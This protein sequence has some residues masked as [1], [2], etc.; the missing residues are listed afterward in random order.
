MKNISTQ[1]VQ[2][3][4]QEVTTVCSCWRLELTDG[5]ILGFTDHVDDLV[6]EG[7][8][9][10]AMT[11]FNRTAI[12]QNRNFK[13]DNHDITGLID[14]LTITESDLLAGR[15]ANAKLYYF[16]VNYE[17]LTQGIVKLDVGYLGDI[18]LKDGIFIAS[19]NSITRKLDQTIG[20]KYSRYCR[21]I[22]GDA[23]CGVHIPKDIWRPN[24]VYNVGDIV[25][26]P[27]LATNV[28]FICITAGTSNISGN[29]LEPAWDTTIG[30]TILDTD[31][32][33]QVEASNGK[34]GQVVSLIDDYS[35]NSTV[36]DADSWYQK[37][38]LVFYSG[39]NTGYSF[40]VK[41]S[42]STGEIQLLTKIYNEINIGDKFF[43]TVGCNH[44]LK[45]ADGTYN[46]DCKIKFNNVL[47][48]GGEPEI[49]GNN[50]ILAGA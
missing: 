38:T 14:S 27:T 37:G 46:G 43:I 16:E 28:Q 5:T 39:A 21:H 25:L 40:D 23:N 32:V 24:T 34:I 1:L 2:H 36:T 13:V 9:Y 29:G 18:T 41:Q 22:L 4:Q 7:V 44:I 48:F 10:E 20:E 19:F 31:V 17:D 47:N 50:K 3:Y 30:N 12:R 15:Y 33:W 49:P 42:F 8:T 11:G 6:I 45:S 26:S 35:F